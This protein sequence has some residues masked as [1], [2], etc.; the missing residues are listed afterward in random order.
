MY[1]WLQPQATSQELLSSSL[2]LPL[3]FCVAF[4]EP[5]DF[6]GAPLTSVHLPY[7][8]ALASFVQASPK[9]KTRTDFES[10]FYCVLNT[11]ALPRSLYLS[12]DTWWFL[13]VVTA[14]IHLLHVCIYTPISDTHKYKKSNKLENKQLFQS[15]L[16]NTMKKGN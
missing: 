9:H 2:A 3:T 16:T 12:V 6:S 11:P 4:R 1:D 15:F 13:T 14:N 5:L 10:H 7:R 8:K